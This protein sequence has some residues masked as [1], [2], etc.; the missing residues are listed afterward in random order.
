MAVSIDWATRVITV[1]Q[2]D[3][4][5]VGPG[6]Y[7]LNVEDFRRWL[8]DIEDS[9]VG[10]AFPDTHR[11]NAP[12]TLSGTTYAQTFEIINGYTVTFENGSYR[13]RVTGGNH[14]IADVMN[15]NSVSIEVGNSAGLIAVGTGGGGG[16]GPTA[17]EIA[18]AV[19]AYVQRGLTERVDADVQAING[20]ELQG[21]GVEGNPMRPV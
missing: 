20:V 6:L 3:L 7:S 10:M 18:A 19:W 8:K 21:A 14:N 2:A 9:E 11:R 12:V 5:Y 13:V 16:G 15:P 4:T 17:G 1:P